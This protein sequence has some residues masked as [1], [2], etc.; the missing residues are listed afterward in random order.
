MKK[1]FHL[2]GQF[3]QANFHR[4]WLFWWSRTALP[5]R[6]RT[7]S[8]A[9]TLLGKPRFKSALTDSY[10]LGYCLVFGLILSLS[11]ILQE[12]KTFNSLISYT[13]RQKHLSEPQ[14]TFTEQKSSFPA[15][16]IHNS[17]Q[18]IKVNKSE[19]RSNSSI[20]F[21]SPLNSGKVRKKDFSWGYQKKCK[22]LQSS[23]E[24][25]TFSLSLKN[26]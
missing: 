20:V 22:N 13:W 14:K 5:V 21:V 9:D 4:N 24:S 19:G 26:I 25:Q 10:T 3:I 16:P 1:R 15:S 8:V 23:S 12:D 11:K 6:E 7:Q 2:K 18:G 17:N